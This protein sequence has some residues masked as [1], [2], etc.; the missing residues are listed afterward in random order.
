MSKYNFTSALVIDLP[1]SA[2][3]YTDEA[4]KIPLSILTCCAMAMF[5]GTQQDAQLSLPEK[6]KKFKL[7]NK[8]RMADEATV[9]EKIVELDSG[10]VTM[11]KECC[12]QLYG[13]LV[14]GQVAEFFESA[15]TPNPL[16]VVK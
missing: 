4:K 9:L 13:T 7:G 16:S 14:V 15:S 6:I 1:N 2:P 8:F 12:N 5:R 11:I 3:V 10:E